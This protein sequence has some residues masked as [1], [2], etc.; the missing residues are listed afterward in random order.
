MNPACRVISVAAAICTCAAAIAQTPNPPPGP[1][2]RSATQ[3]GTDIT[4]TITPVDPAAGD[5]ST[6][7]ELENVLVRVKLTD[8][9][10]GS[11]LPGALPAAWVDSHHGADLITQSQ[12]VGEVKRFA[13]GSTFSHAQLDLTSFYVVLMN[14]DATL[15][16]VDPRFGYGDTRLLAMVALDGP[17][18]D[19]AVTENAGSNAPMLA[20]NRQLGFREFRAGTEYQITR[21][22]LTAK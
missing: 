5:G 16:V 13:E 11:P 20:I 12:C 17:A 4:V 15:T 7:Q 10:T 9:V 1:Y 6:L 3:N 8:K 2:T 18:E 22:R 21:D 19:W 14:T